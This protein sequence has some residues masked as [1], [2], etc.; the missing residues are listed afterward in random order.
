MRLTELEI[1]NYQKI[2][3]V[4]FTVKR[5]V[6]EIAGPNGAGKS[7]AL[8]AIAVWLDGLRAAPAEP[9]RHGALRSR[10]R[11]RLG[12]MYVIRTIERTKKGELTTQIKFEPVGEKAYPV[13][14]KQLTDLIGEH[15]LDP[16]D[17]L[18]LDVKGK[19]DAMRAF[20]P[21]FDFAKCKQLNDADYS[22]RTEANKLA[23]DSEAAAEL[24]TIPP[25][26]PTESIDEQALV[27]ELQEAGQFNTEL[28]ARRNRRSQVA[29][30]AQ[31]HR[32]AAAV[33]LAAIE[34]VRPAKLQE[35]ATWLAGQQAEIAELEQKIAAIRTRIT[36]AADQA[37]KSIV[38][39]ENEIRAQ[40]AAA[41]AEAERL[42]KLLADAGELPIAKNADDITA[43][44]NQARATNALVRRAEERARH[45]STA[46][47][48]RDES[49]QLTAS[50]EARETAKQKAIGD[51]QLPIA[52]IEFG[53]GEIRYNGV[54]FEQA[55]TAQKLTVAIARIVALQPKLRLA[56]IR[57]ASLFDDD[58]L[59]TLDRLA[60][61]FE[62]DI[63][64]ETVRPVA[65]DAVVL[66]DGHVRAAEAP[67][68]QAEAVA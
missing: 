24:I 7:S 17:F 37:E 4:Q 10:I 47:R 65:N 25:G 19:F 39:G 55:S 43:R 32:D 35:H 44:I 26:T 9:I 34:Q 59:A 51:A 56:W 22:R 15:N 18:G 62:C 31:C 29:A 60:Q 23:K 13:T 63:L 40:A 8:N 14:Q 30:S 21:G 45:V 41:T 20:V 11:G 52:G 46:K 67:Q 54:P 36:A 1:E 33:H 42:E 50:M 38:E 2:T 53:D 64:I 27:R 66:Q 3:L 57:D 12:E 49:E 68:P 6:T 5:G 48:Y 58:A 16:N 28:E 61:E